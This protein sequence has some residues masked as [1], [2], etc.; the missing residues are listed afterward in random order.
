MQINFLGEGKF[1]IKTKNAKILTGDKIQINDFLIPGKGEYEIAEVAVEYLEDILIFNAEEIN[2][3]YLDQRNKPLND[4]EMEQISQ[5]DILF[6]PVAGANVYT[7]K[8][9]MEV[10]NQ[11]EPKIII[12]M[13]YDKIEEFSQQ[14]GIKVETM[15]T[16]KIS[17]SQITDESRK[18]IIL[19]CKP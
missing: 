16:L 18:I 3:V 15:E 9:A 6:L 12:P 1:E 17:K 11:I 8:Q 10:I 13:H 2:L 7:V 5:A 19:T 4:E 14:E